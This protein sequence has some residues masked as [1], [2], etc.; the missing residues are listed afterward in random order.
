MGRAEDSPLA[1]WASNGIATVTFWQIERN[2]FPDVFRSS[3]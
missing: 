2:E 1:T 3:R